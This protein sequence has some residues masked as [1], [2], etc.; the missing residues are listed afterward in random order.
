MIDE[1]S[2]V[3]ALI[4]QW[5]NTDSSW[6]DSRERKQ[7]LARER[8]PLE[9]AEQLQFWIRHS[10]F[11]GVSEKLLAAS[12]ARTRGN[13]SWM[14][15]QG[16]PRNVVAWIRC[17]VKW[18]CLRNVAFYI[19]K[20][21]DFADRGESG[22]GKG[23]RK[24]SGPAAEKNTPEDCKT[25]SSLAAVLLPLIFDFRPSVLVKYYNR[26]ICSPRGFFSAA[27]PFRRSNS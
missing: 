10:V 23:G 27:L 3:S 2:R 7:V 25:S 19:W 1:N 17:D 13:N 6:H 24:R 12:R 11:D 26:Q 22:D 5:W 18:L 15:I 9:K 8:W 16:G 4:I 14:V 21:L 20:K